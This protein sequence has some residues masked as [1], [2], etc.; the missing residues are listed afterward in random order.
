MSV[1]MSVYMSVYVFSG[2]D[3][4]SL[5]NK[6]SSGWKDG[7]GWGGGA[8]VVDCAGATRGT[9]GWTFCNGLCN[10]IVD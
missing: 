8:S 2:S 1:S 3:S 10:N 5:M 6:D 4:S 9:G 7:H